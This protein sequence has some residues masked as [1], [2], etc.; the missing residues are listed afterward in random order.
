[1]LAAMVSRPPLSHDSPQGSRPVGGAGWSH[2]HPEES[3]PAQA[4]DAQRGGHHRTPPT[5]RLE[6]AAQHAMGGPPRFS[7]P[8]AGEGSMPNEVPP[9]KPEQQSSHQPPE[10]RDQV[11]PVAQQPRGASAGPAAQEVIYHGTMNH[12]VSAGGYIKWT[13]VCIAGGFAAWGLGHISFVAS[14]PLWLLSLVG[15][16]GM[17]WVFLRHVTTRYKIT[18]QRV[19]YERG[20]L[21]KTVDSLELWR[22]LDVRYNQSLIDRILGN[23]KVVLIGTDQTDPELVLYGLPNHRLLF[24][25]LRDAVQAA[26]HTSRPMELVGQDGM[27]ENVGISQ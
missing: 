16:P 9:Q 2:L 7:Q 5:Q 14:W 19:E 15:I 24:E 27:V 10:R 4:S 17:V 18:L 21:S 23:A 1:M 20:V 22:I 6:A 12:S 25:K 26:R 8:S 13:L 3:G 11:R